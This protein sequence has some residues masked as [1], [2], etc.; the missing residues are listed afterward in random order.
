[1]IRYS[2]IIEYNEYTYVMETGSAFPDPE[3]AISRLPKLIP[4][5]TMW[6]RFLS[7]KVDARVSVV[8]LAHKR[9]STRLSNM[10]VLIIEQAV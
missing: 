8:R 3:A 5:L 2:T 1:M 9:I 4:L 10:V 7:M 6:S